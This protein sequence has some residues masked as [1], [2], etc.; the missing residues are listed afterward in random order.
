[1][2]RYAKPNVLAGNALSHARPRLHLKGL[3]TY[4]ISSEEDLSLSNVRVF[5]WLPRDQLPKIISIAK[6]IVH[7]ELS[8]KKNNTLLTVSA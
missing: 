2:T 3:K 8:T 5:R 6:M 1:M 7:D 4:D